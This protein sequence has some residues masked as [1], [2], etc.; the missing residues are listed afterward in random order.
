MLF[1]NVDKGIIDI[2][3]GVNLCALHKNDSGIRLIA[4]ECTLRRMVPKICCKYYNVVLAAKFQPVQLGF[5]SKGGC[6]AAI[7][8]LFIY[9]D[10]RKEE[11]ILKVHQR[12]VNSSAKIK[13]PKIY[14]FLWQPYRYPT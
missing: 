12:N 13:T 10:C 14:N 9:L 11:V 4:V 7:H 1:D 6:E 3:Y 2:L 8:A 5:G